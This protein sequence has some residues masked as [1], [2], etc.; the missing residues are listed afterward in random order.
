MNCSV[1]EMLLTGQG[2]YKKEGQFCFIGLDHCFVN[3]IDWNFNGHGKLWNYN[4][5]Y[6]NYLLDEDIPVN[7]RRGL[8]DD[9]SIALLNGVIKPEPYPVSLRIINSLLFHSRH[10]IL[11][12][13]TLKALKFQVD[14]LNHNLEYHLLGNHLLENC[15]ALFIAAHALNNQQLY[16]RSSRLLTK[17]LKEQ[18][19]SDGGHYERTPMYHSIL[20]SRLLLCIEIERNHN[21]FESSILPILETTASK[22]LGWINAFSFPDGSWALM[23]DAAKGVAPETNQ[24]NRASDYLQLEWKQIEL[25]ESGFRKLKG[26]SWE[27]LLNVGNILPSYQPGHTHADMLSFCIWHKDQQVVVDPGTSTYAITQQRL[28]ERGTTAHN[29]ITINKKN[30]SDV[31]GGFRIGKRA[32]CQLIKE[33]DGLIIACVNNYAGLPIQHIREFKANEN[34]LEL[35]DTASKLHEG[36]IKFEGSLLLKPGIN[37]VEQDVNILLDSVCIYCNAPKEIVATITAETFNQVTPTKRV[38]YSALGEAK[39]RFEFL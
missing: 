38:T 4:L 5:Q 18:V 9:L 28:W 15:Y 21:L 23:N 2:E 39:L 11:D 1:H 12:V 27:M 35:K 29:T 14:Y 17:Q 3:G 22:M 36:P 32:K 7:T 34:S 10:G 37:V 25:R 6:L 20:L 19:L 30:Q 8:L 13:N 16:H 24:L 26:K 31:W 33:E